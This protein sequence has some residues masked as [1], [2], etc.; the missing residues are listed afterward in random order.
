M[1]SMPY[2]MRLSGWSGLGAL[3]ASLALFNASAHL[4]VG[5]LEMLPPGVPRSYPS[6]GAAAFGTKG[7]RLVGL[8]ALSEFGG[9]AIVTFAIVFHQII[10]IFPE[11]KLSLVAPL[12]FAATVPMLA[13]PSFKSL[14]PLSALGCFSGLAVGTAVLACVVWDPKREHYGGNWGGIGFGGGGVAGVRSALATTKP[15][16]TPPP[17][18]PPGHHAVGIGILRAIG[19]FSVSVSGHSSLPALRASMKNP[20]QFVRFFNFVYFF[21][22]FFF[23]YKKKL[24]P[25]L[26]PFFLKKII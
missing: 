18:S 22:S 4:L 19:I 3:L 17:S 14:T 25:R 12:S 2:A 6:L 20:E 21:P 10:I 16:P 15:R 8:L 7:R 26:Q 11:C 9:G 23:G 5:G 13:L 1:L 24:T